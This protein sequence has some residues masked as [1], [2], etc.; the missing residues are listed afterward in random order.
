M[1]SLECK[2]PIKSNPKK[3]IGLVIIGKLRGM[4]VAFRNIEKYLNKYL[5]PIIYANKNVHI[6]LF[7]STKLNLKEL[8]K[9]YLTKI[10]PETNLKK[11]FFLL[12]L[13]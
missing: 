7:E 5:I 3:N 2:S 11:D 6:F 9:K 4:P 12:R 1:S 8:P 10:S 13:F